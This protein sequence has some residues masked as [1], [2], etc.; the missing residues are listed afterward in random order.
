[1]QCLNAMFDIILSLRLQIFCGHREIHK[2]Q[3]FGILLTVSSYIL[4]PIAMNLTHF[5][6]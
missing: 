5:I 2:I 3:E 4:P 1:M 6:C